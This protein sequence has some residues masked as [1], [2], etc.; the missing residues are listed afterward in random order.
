VLAS[1]V[2][3]NAKGRATQLTVPIQ[4]HAGAPRELG[5][6]TFLGSTRCGNRIRRRRVWHRI[7]WTRCGTGVRLLHAGVPPDRPLRPL[8]NGGQLEYSGNG[9]FLDLN[10][11]QTRRVV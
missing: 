11:G 8:Q 7:Q 9:L 6:L 10:L 5:S 2:D 1:A 4:A 3:M